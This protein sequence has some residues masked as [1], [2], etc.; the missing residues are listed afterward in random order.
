MACDR[1]GRRHRSGRG[2]TARGQHRPAAAVGRFF[3]RCASTCASQI[4]ERS[5]ASATARSARESH[6]GAASRARD[7]SPRQSPAIA[8]RPTIASPQIGLP[9]PGLTPALHRR[10]PAAAADLDPRGV[11]LGGT[12]DPGRHVA[13][14]FGELVAIDHDLAAAGIR[15]P[16][17]RLSGHST[18]KIAATV[19]SANTNHS[20]IKRFRMERRL[21]QALRIALHTAASRQLTLLDRPKTKS[22]VSGAVPAVSQQLTWP[23]RTRP[24]Y[25]KQP[26]QRSWRP[27]RSD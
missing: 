16:P 2:A 25:R 19:I 23:R 7:R 11:G 1:R 9:A 13:V 27:R 22:A 18:A 17:G 15:A 10:R 8:T 26:M 20:V 21:R 12:D 6:R 4:G 5:V 14:D 24:K 3:S